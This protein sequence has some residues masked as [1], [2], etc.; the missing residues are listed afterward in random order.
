MPA[1]APAQPVRARTKVFFLL[2]GIFA[3]YVFAE[4]LANVYDFVRPPEHNSYWVYEDSGR[5]V[6]FDPILGHR[7]A[8]T[9]S[10]VAA[11]SFG[12]V[13]FIGVLK[14]NSQGVQSRFDFGPERTSPGAKRVAIFG[15]SYTAGAEMEWNWPDRIHQAAS[16]RGEPLDI[17]NF[18][19]D[20]WGL[21]N[22]SHV[23]THMLEP[24]NYELDA[25]VFA[26]WNVDLDR[27]YHFSD[28]RGYDRWAGGHA[29]SWD[30][31][32]Y[33]RTAEEAR[34]LQK[35][36]DF[37][38]IVSHEQFE[39]ALRGE[40]APPVTRQFRLHLTHAITARLARWLRQRDNSRPAPGPVA[41]DPGRERLIQ[42]I[43]RYAEARHIPVLVVYLPTLDTAARTRAP[44]RAMEESKL[45][46]KEIG[47]DFVDGRQA[48]AN[49][50][51]AQLKNEWRTFDYH[52][53][54]AGSDRF[55]KFMHKILID[56]LASR[57]AAPKN[58]KPAEAP[59]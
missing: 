32:T 22:W 31:E 27:K 19:L 12:R 9:P 51:A 47:G 35:L 38:Y 29:T 54:E 13:K 11:L 37:T 30:P 17:L 50:T 20:G 26:V 49:M 24:Q 48:Y 6:H 44:G 4:L 53:N 55:A 40:W 10:R 34:P 2:A 3:G 15:D 59:K 18:S 25:L 43:R 39:Q 28:H 46:A 23:V 45:F 16:D 14:G 57:A 56:W 52:W 42:D 1:G 41:F 5:T 8:T 21:A 33:P 58:S 7:L 36:S